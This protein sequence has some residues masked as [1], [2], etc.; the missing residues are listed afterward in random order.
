M[1]MTEN[2][3]NRYLAACKIELQVYNRRAKAAKE[4]RNKIADYAIKVEAIGFKLSRFSK[5]LDINNSTLM[6]W[7]YKRKD[8]T[9]VIE[10][11]TELKSEGKV[12][13][14]SIIARVLK[15][16][17]K[18]KSPKITK[19]MYIMESERSREDIVLDNC[20]APLSRIQFNICSEYVL[21][22]VDQAT[23]MTI[24]DIC[25]LITE[26]IDTHLGAQSEKRNSTEREVLQ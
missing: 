26:K 25:T 10:L 21:S 1:G 22:G 7:V 5:D 2:K 9:K 16:S 8:E 4:S 24:Y 11:K 13:D 6:D 15:K 3:Y 18:S 23:L 20:I 19:D 14:P 12:V 17:S